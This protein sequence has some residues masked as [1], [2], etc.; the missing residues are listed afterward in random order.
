M[1]VKEDRFNY[2]MRS[3][4]VENAEEDVI[5]F[6]RKHKVAAAAG[7]ATITPDQKAMAESQA[8]QEPWLDPVSMLTSGLTGGASLAAKGISAA[9]DPVMNWIMQNMGGKK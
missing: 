4:L 7:I 3:G 8:L 9:A 5:N 2:G 6:L 1:A